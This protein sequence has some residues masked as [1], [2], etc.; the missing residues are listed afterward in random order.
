MF[1]E[2][3]FDLE[4]FLNNNYDIP[5]PKNVKINHVFQVKKRLHILVIIKSS[6]ARKILNRIIRSTMPTVVHR[7]RSQCK[8]IL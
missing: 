7:E 6:T 3:F 2:D 1:H 4:S 8:N 5:D